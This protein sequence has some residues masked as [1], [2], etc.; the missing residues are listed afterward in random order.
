MFG[1]FWTFSDYSTQQA[2]SFCP[3]AWTYVCMYVA[4]W[5]S[6]RFFEE[7]NDVQFDLIQAV[8]IVTLT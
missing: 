5:T 4:A 8:N 7:K 2:F 1:G 3:A 6:N